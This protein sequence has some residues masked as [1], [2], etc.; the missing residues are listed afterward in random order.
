M[1]RFAAMLRRRRHVELSNWVGGNESQG[2]QW[3]SHYYW[4]PPF[5]PTGDDT[6]TR[7]DEIS[8]VISSP[9]PEDTVTNST[10]HQVASHLSPLILQSTQPNSHLCLSDF[11]LCP[12]SLL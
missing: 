6:V 7:W 4:S 1:N 5:T 3:D 8:P 2:L 10:S 9:R 11:S 12:P